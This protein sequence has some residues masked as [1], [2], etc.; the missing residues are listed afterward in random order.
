[1]L[2]WL[3]IHAE[4]SESLPDPNFQAFIQ[5]VPML[6]TWSAMKKSIILRRS[7]SADHKSTKKVV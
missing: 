6:E 2:I 7:Q 4:E 1:M 5:L 3:P